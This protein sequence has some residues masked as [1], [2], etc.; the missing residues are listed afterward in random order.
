MRLYYKDITGLIKEPYLSSGRDYFNKGKVQIISVDES[1]AK[2]KVVG[3]SKY[4][5][6]LK[7]DGPLFSGTCSCPAFCYFGP[8]KHMAATGFTLIDL[9]RKEYRSSM[10]LGY[11]DKQTLLER[12]LLK[13]TNKELISIIVRLGDQHPE[14]FEELE[15]EEYEQFT[16][17]KFSKSEN[18]V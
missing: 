16:Q 8:C 13:K 9:D 6:T 1:H 5:V 3:S 15:D 10:C 14:I 11:V 7:H 18:Y 4:Q 12:F 17:S 2:S